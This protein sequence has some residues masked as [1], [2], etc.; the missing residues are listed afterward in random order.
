MLH[1]ARSTRSSR[2]CNVLV[3]ELLSLGPLAREL[4]DGAVVHR[5]RRRPRTTSEQAH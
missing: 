1:V 5:L 2:N 4:N 3:R